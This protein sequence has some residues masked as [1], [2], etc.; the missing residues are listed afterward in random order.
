MNLPLARMARLQGYGMTQAADSYLYRPGTI[1]DARQVFETA[2]QTGLQVVLRGAGRSYGDPSIGAETLAI[3]VSRMNSVLSWD[4]ETG[5]LEAEPGMTIEGVWRHCLEDGW[6][7]YVVSGTMFPTLAG[8]IAMNIHGKNNFRVGTFGEHVLEID[9]LTPRGQVLGIKPDDPRFE[10][11]VGGLGLLG[12]VTRVKMQLKK[13]TSG[14]LKVLPVSCA[15]WDE[16]FATFEEFEPTADYMV[17]WV[18]AFGRGKGAGRGDF[19]AAWY[20]THSDPASLRPEHQDLPDTIM[21]FWPK[22]TVWRMLK[23]LN[24][25]SG[26]RFTN[27]AKHT[28][29]THLGDRK[30]ITQSLV[31]FSFLLDYVPNWRMAYLPHGFLQFQ[32]F[33][34]KDRAKEIFAEQIR[35]QQAYRLESYLAVLKRHRPDRFLLSHALDGYSLALDFKV[36]PSTRPKLLELCHKMAELVLNAG[37]R[38]YFAKDSVLTAEEAHRFLGEE[39][40]ARFRQIK[41]EMDPDHLLTSGLT[42]RL[43]LVE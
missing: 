23:V 16:Q 15:N 9:V 4:P 18:D 32:S 43:R 17:S 24:R 20:P 21:G 25:R 2:R 26:M 34:P 28:A 3:D 6:W 22:S 36:T 10:A 12:M 5:I 42:K 40:L 38:F 14:D 8:A 30:E 37:G 35:L 19:H 11:V 41:D 33:V 39:S 31:G 7:P 1:E 13:V 27:W 29:S